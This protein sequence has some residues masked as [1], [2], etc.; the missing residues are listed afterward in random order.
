MAEVKQETRSRVSG[1]VFG[2]VLGAAIALVQVTLF[3]LGSTIYE[4][5]AGVT[6]AGNSMT[7]FVLIPLVLIMTFGALGAAFSNRLAKRD[8]RSTSRF[9]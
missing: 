3:M 1:A 2:V 9:V 8:Q 5:S 6:A 4:P 7:G